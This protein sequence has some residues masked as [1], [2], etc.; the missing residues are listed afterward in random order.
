[1]NPGWIILEKAESKKQLGRVVGICSEGKEQ[2]C[3]YSAMLL[4]AHFALK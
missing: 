1:L 4:A 3:I 2:Y